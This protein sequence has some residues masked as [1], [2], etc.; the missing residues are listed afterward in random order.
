MS[1]SRVD[2][3]R[4]WLKRVA[5]ASIAVL[6]ISACS[7]DETL[8]APGCNNGSGLI[9]AQSVPTA[10][11]IPCFQELPN[12]WSFDRVHIGQDGTFVR[13]DSDRAGASAATFRF[14]TTCEVGDATLTAG[15]FEGTQRYV[16]QERN[17]A[18]FRAQV[19]IVSEGGCVTWNFDFNRGAPGFIAAELQAALG[20]VLREDLNDNIRET[21]IDEEL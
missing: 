8:P 15:T 17:R 12:G 14:T 16:L 1:T 4:R 20:F 7:V 11:V 5:V 6:V 10:Q 21:F 3:P 2:A 19:F 9:A 13:L 18:S